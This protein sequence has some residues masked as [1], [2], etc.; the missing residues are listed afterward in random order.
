MKNGQDPTLNQISTPAV[1]ANGHMIN[2]VTID[3][4]NGRGSV[5]YNQDIDYFGMKVKMRPSVFLKLCTPLDEDDTTEMEEY[6][7]NG[8]AIGAPFLNI[9]I[10][11]EW[12]DGNFDKSARITNHEGRHRMKA[13][14]AVDGDNPV[15][16]HLLVK[17]YR[18]R[19]LTLEIKKQIN[20]GIFR[21]GQQGFLVG[22]LFSLPLDEATIN[23]S[24]PG[25]NVTKFIGDMY[26]KYQPWT[27]NNN[28]RVMVWGQ[29]EDQQ[30]AI[31]EL[32]PSLSKKNSVEVVWFAAHPK[33][34][35]V[36][37]RAMKELQQQ[38]KEY[39]LGLTLF[40]WDKGQVSQ[41]KLIKFYKQAGFSPM[42]KGGKSMSWA[43]DSINEGGWASI[44]TQNTVIT[45]A[46]I[47]EAITTLNQF[48]NEYNAWQEKN[49]L[50][51][52][53]DIGKPVGSG[54]YYLRDLAQNP[55][56]EYG[57]I[58]VMCFI[59]SLPDESAAQRT[60][61]YRTAIQSFCQQSGKYSTESGV[62]IIVE[63]GAGA[64]QVDLVLT[65]HE[66][67]NWARALAP[68]YKVKGAINSSLTSAMAEVL[69]LSF[70]VQGV[71]VKLR[72]KR[73]VSF[74]QS[75]DTELQSVT[76]DPENWGPDIFKFYYQLAHGSTPDRT[77]GD[78]ETH[79]GLKDEQRISDIIM[80]I[81]SLAKDLYIA[82]LL[83]N[84]ALD[85]I[86]DSN[87][88]LRKIA[89]VFRKKIDTIINSS[90]FDK[91]QTPAAIKKAE[92]TKVFFAKYRDQVTE[93]LI[94]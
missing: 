30:F 51:M 57:D 62:N 14:L 21:E 81:R 48:G 22:P 94:K 8:G 28:Q 10:P 33:R 34:E 83:G 23:I 78:L 24:S 56:R 71:Q 6:I 2:E 93:L 44:A 39:G 84:G 32:K 66:H 69:N 68:E 77:P 40:P 67:K 25:S 80:V 53:V 46:V 65:F 92:D 17:Y 72:A 52:P 19:E 60:A 26:A 87:D 31:F 43:P 88:M 85:S 76:I 64:V 82:G 1:I 13:V 58:D 4:V 86:A 41:N 20:S 70:G 7:R 47:D 35:G 74:R 5:P 15:E 27:M 75:K 3:N 9:T 55:T 59:T 29:G 36:G 16:T 37:S 90:K 91:A 42:K 49:N 50:G 38:A 18:A 11:P 79:R 45:P 61:E 73:P 54:T 12:D 89:D 63:T